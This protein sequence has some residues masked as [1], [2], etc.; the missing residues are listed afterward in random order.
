M[1]RVDFVQSSFTRGILSPRIRGRIDFE[2]LFSGAEDILNGIVLPQG[3]LIRRPGTRHVAEVKDSTK[4][5]RLIPFIV[6]NEQA[7]VIELGDGYARFYRDEGRLESAGT[8][9][10]IVTPWTEAQLDA[11]SWTQSADVLYV[12]HPDEEPREI[13]RLTVTSFQVQ[14]HEFR[15]GPYLP[16]N[17]TATTLTPDSVSGTVTFTASS[18]TGINDDTGFQSSDVLR[19]LRF[20]AD[21]GNWR[22]Y[23]IDSV[24]N[25]TTIVTT[26]ETGEDLPNLT[27]SDTWRLGEWSDTTGWPRAVGFHAERLWWGG[28]TDSPQ[29]IWGSRVGVFT[30]HSPSLND[31]T[32]LD[33]DAI[34]VTISNNT[35]NNIRW[36]QSV[37][38]GLMIGTQGR[39]VLL[40]P[41]TTTT[42]I[43]PGNVTVNPQSS[44]GSKENTM[45]TLVSKS[46]VFIQRDGRTINDYAFNFDVNGFDAQSITVIAESL[47][48]N[49]I[50]RIEFQQSP[51]NVIWALTEDGTLAGMTVEK[52]QRVFGWHRHAIADSAA[53]I[54]KLEDIAV[55]PEPTKDQLWLVMQRNINGSTKRYISFME[56]LF[57]GRAQDLLAFFVDD[58]LTLNNPI[59]GGIQNITQANPG[60]VTMNS[61]HGLS[62]GDRIRI[63]GPLFGMVEVNRRQ[64][65]VNNV[66]ATTFELQNLDGVNVDTTSFSAW[67]SNASASAREE[68]TIISGLSHLE[69]ETVRILADGAVHPD[70]TVSTGQITLDRFASIV[71]VGLGYESE[72]VLLPVESG[73]EQT[74]TV[75]RKKRIH[76]VHTRLLETVGTKVGIK[77]EDLQPILFRD[78]RAPMNDRTPLFT[79]VKT[80]NIKSRWEQ[81]LQVRA[82]SDHALPWQMLNIAI[83]QQ[84]EGS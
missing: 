70:K 37:A 14:R 61:G 49:G 1:A 69:G 50:K 4:K 21:D 55:I 27:A 38:E 28:T 35:V 81:E 17:L 29:T 26:Q 40:S 44:H 16:V 3:G 53:G 62:N 12:A 65:K 79:G 33:T 32:V 39:E 63:R 30:R 42:G 41:A 22:S 19:K 43:A 46:V 8:P 18:T 24:T 84:V 64:F 83:E 6:S 13:R 66:T 45:S 54:G 11:V 5:V 76:Q 56:D 48:R 10:E 60:V 58:G 75:G 77:S 34:N 9:V 73:Q 80:V 51:E 25:S 7:Y 72:V 59:G 47:F 23:E 67:D 31:G 15:D 20:Q 36:F 74:S 57:E 2:G 68:V 71:H 82:T 52:A 78:P